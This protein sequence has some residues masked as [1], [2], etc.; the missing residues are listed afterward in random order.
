MILRSVSKHT[1][2]RYTCNP[3]YT[4]KFTKDETLDLVK[5]YIDRIGKYHL[6]RSMCNWSTLN[7]KLDIIKCAKHVNREWISGVQDVWCTDKIKEWLDKQKHTILCVFDETAPR[8]GPRIVEFRG[9]VG[10][11]NIRS[12]VIKLV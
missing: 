11:D 4:E 2:Q 8:Y 9:M 5:Y 7:D 3:A 1:P 6:Y 10:E 12:A